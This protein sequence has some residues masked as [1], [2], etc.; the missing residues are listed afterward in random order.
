MWIEI[1]KT[2]NLMIASLWKDLFDAEG[3]TALVV[4]DVPDWEGVSDQQPRRVMVP[5]DKK[6]VAE[7]VMRKL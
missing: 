3:V 2:P 5:L 1:A 6:H 7:E 4:P